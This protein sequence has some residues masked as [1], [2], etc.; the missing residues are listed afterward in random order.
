MTKKKKIK[1]VLDLKIREVFICW[2][3]CTSN[4]SKFRLVYWLSLLWK[5]EKVIFLSH[6]LFFHVSTGYLKSNQSQDSR[7]LA[8]GNCSEC[9][10]LVLPPLEKRL[11][12]WY[13]VRAQHSQQPKSNSI[14]T[15]SCHI[16]Y[17][18]CPG[19]MP[20]CRESRVRRGTFHCHDNFISILNTDLRCARLDHIG[21]ALC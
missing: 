2:H 21:H 3:K 11:R 12:G 1:R 10:L 8:F 16:P 19:K 4:L 6:W 13:L 14:L 18:S 7:I 9:S 20:I 17:P 15:M 5:E